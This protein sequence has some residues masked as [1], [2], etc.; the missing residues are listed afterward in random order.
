MVSDSL[1]L[2][3]ALRVLIQDFFLNDT[4]VDRDRYAFMTGSE[5]LP[6]VLIQ[7]IHVFFRHSSPINVISKN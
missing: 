1:G 2:A 5:D 4:I 7:N 6:P 3:R